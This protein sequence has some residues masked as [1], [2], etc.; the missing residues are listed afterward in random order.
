MAMDS[1]A[2]LDELLANS[3]EF[4]DA[5]SDSIHS[6]TNAEQPPLRLFADTVA[7]WSGCADDDPAASA[8]TAASRDPRIYEVDSDEESAAQ[9]HQSPSAL[10]N[11][12]NRVRYRPRTTIDGLPNG[13]EKHWQQDGGFQ[14]L[15]QRC[16]MMPTLQE[17]AKAPNRA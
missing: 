2:R 8:A 14:L 6:A 13:S 9:P 5:D 4:D 10:M 16:I 7:D 3:L 17:V 11:A 12:L 1:R 15:R